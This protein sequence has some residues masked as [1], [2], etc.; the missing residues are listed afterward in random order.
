LGIA[1]TDIARGEFD[2][3][4][5]VRKV[6]AQGEEATST[7]L[8][9]GIGYITAML[10]YIMIAI[11]GQMV[12]RSVLEEK[13]SRIMEVVIS[14]VRP[15]QLLM[16]KLLAVAAIGLTQLLMWA[17]LIAALYLW[18]LAPILLGSGL[19]STPADGLPGGPSPAAAQAMSGTITAA[20]QSFDFTV[21]WLLPVY[22]LGGFLM[23]GSLYAALA[24]S[25]DQESDVQS[26][27]WVV[28]VPLILP[29]MAMPAVV[30]APSS[31]L[32][33]WFSQ[34][35]FFSPVIM[36][37]RLASSDVPTWQVVMSLLLLVGGIIGM[38][39]VA[40]RIYRVG[41][42]MYGQKPTIGRLVKW[43]FMRG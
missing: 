2:L 27:S 42:L 37:L 40:G 15:F 19:P 43:V 29:I 33:V 23:F 7:A 17:L 32:A 21:L 10:I 11:Y 12:M 30:A 38:L 6:R 24:A 18:V 26:I 5:A 3:D 14:S 4:L 28:F 41:V 25:A 35:P 31:G 34:V 9:T 39:W 36:M 8:A 20:L 1:E 13:T 22:F 16:G